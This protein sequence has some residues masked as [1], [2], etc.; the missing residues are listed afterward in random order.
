M[1]T[2]VVEDVEV[3]EEA[4]EFDELEEKFFFIEEEETTLIAQYVDENLEDFAGPPMIEIIK[5]TT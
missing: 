5:T 4:K 3:F 2:D 1:S